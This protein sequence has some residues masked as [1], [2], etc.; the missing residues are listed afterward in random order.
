MEGRPARAVTSHEFREIMAKLKATME[1]PEMQQKLGRNQKWLYSLDNDKIHRGAKLHLVGLKDEDIF[2]LPELSSDMHKV[3]EHV[4]A[5]LQ[6]EMQLWLEEQDE[7][8][9]TVEQCKAE[10]RRLFEQ[11]L[12]QESIKKDVAGLKKTYA[13][14]V[15]AGGG[16][17]PAALR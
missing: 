5:W 11:K 4:H 1:T 14:V 6:A 15:A 8:K 3:V 7:H 2:E 16:M 13:A 12:T 9:I 10:L 17:I